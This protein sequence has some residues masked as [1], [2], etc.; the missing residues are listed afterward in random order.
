MEKAVLIELL[1]TGVKMTTE[2]LLGGAFHK[3][4]DEVS[5]IIRFDEDI[6]EAE[7]VS[8]E[9]FSE[10]VKTLNNYKA[11]A[12]AKGANKI[13]AYASTIFQTMRSSKK[14]FEDIFKKTN[15]FF[16]VLTNEEEIRLIYNAVSGSVETTKGVIFY[17]NPHNTYVMNF[18]KRSLMSSYTLPFG[19]NSLAHKFKCDEKADAK[20]ITAQ[21]LSYIRTEIKAQNMQW[22][23]FEEVKFVAA[24]SL[25]LSLSALV[26]KMTHYPLNA[27]NNYF[28]SK[29]NIDKA[30]DLLVSQG[31][32]RT[33]RIAGVSAERLDNFISGTAIA[34]AFCEEKEVEL[35]N[36]AARGITEAL[37][38][39]KIVRESTCEGTPND[40]LEVSLK[41]IRYYYPI[42]ESN[43][44]NVYA[45]TFE[46]FHQMSIVH[47]LGRKYV[48]ALKIATTLYDCGKRITF[49]NHTK[50]SKDII[51]NSEILNV[52]HRDLIVA[53]FACQLQNLENF[54]LA[55]WVKY[56]AIVDEEDL[57]AARKIGGLI[58]LAS[59]LD[60]GKQNKIKEINCDLLGDI[61][62]I[63]AK[64]EADASYEIAEANKYNSTFKK[65]FNKT[66][67][68]M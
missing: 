35:L 39:N 50:Y 62:I 30:F 58:A 4:I 34:K 41:N 36:I 16:T 37:I 9:K 51:L 40:L 27:A 10:C 60:S 47:K 5:D 23:E 66:Y 28:L 15:I 18:A 52:N 26:R 29:S 22:E 63:K 45:L 55:E 67:Q 31:F 6:Y 59:A 57:V 19:S 53:A 11:L 8:D 64:T 14:F 3:K 61:V 49:E 12:M 43:S 33:K 65:I 2:K 56:Q 68:I 48:K 42:D 46:L 44:E 7:T 1:P 25:M 20:K 54:N 21:M 13:Y 17:I 38:S 24:G 32:N